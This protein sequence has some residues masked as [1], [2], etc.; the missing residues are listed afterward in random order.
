[1]VLYLT[2]DAPVGSG[3]GLYKHK[4]TGLRTKPDDKELAEELDSQ[5]QDFTAWEMTDY[6]GNIFNRAVIYRGE[7]YHSAVQYFGTTDEYCRMHQTFFF[8][9]K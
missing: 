5:A 6:V 4:K 9:S 8:S 1:M 7:Y 3:T 2:P